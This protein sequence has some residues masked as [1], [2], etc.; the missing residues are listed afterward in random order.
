MFKYLRRRAETHR[1]AAELMD[2]GAE[3][4]RI[5][6]CAFASNPPAKLILLGEIL[7]DVRFEETG[8]IAWT[9]VTREQLSRTRI[10]RDDLRDLIVPL[11]EI[12]D[13]EIALLFK[14]RADG[15]CTVSLRSKGNIPVDRIA[16]RLG[17]GGHAFAAGAQ[18]S[19]PWQDAI[20][21]ALALTRE[22]F[23]A[24]QNRD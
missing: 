5:Y 1:I 21:R 20:S 8:R 10:R 22:A 13:V 12:S 3:T 17:G 14:E 19:G 24:A 4:D 18:V 23:Q 11:L 16:I 2:L 7:R 15:H 6:R 9:T